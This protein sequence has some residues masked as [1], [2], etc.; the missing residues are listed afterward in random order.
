MLDPV[1]LA[2]RLIDCESVTPATGAVFDR[3]AGMLE[4]LG[5][6][7]HRFVAGEAP[8]GPCAHQIGYPARAS[9]LAEVDEL[10]KIAVGH[11]PVSLECCKNLYVC[12]VHRHKLLHSRTWTHAI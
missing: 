7:I 1:F 12:G 2:E 9:C 3:L 11:A 4:P 6:T 5:F 8:D 10:T